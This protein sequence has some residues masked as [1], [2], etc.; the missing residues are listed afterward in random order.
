[1]V[2]SASRNT[3]F[4]AQAQSGVHSLR[5]WQRSGIQHFRI[6]LVDETPYDARRIVRTYVNV[7][8]GLC[9]PSVAW[10]ILQEC[11]DSNG[12][13]AGVTLGSFENTKKERRAGQLT[14]NTNKKDRRAG[15]ST[16]T[17]SSRTR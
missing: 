6:E 5:Q 7:W 11:R 9:K 13:V 17:S 3:V 12:R 2:I 8:K 14:E 15:Q 10:D 4:A 1:M 16:K